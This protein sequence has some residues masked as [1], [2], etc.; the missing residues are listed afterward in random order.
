[1]QKKCHLP[2]NQKQLPN[3]TG[4]FSVLA[5]SSQCCHFDPAHGA[6]EKSMCTD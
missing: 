4:W 5:I 1:M 3:F 2:P 6:G